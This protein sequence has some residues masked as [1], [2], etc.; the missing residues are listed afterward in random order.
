MESKI[1]DLYEYFNIPRNGAAAG[2]L[3]TYLRTPSL[4]IKAK[5]RPAVL[6]I[7]GGAYTMVSDREGEPVALSFLSEGYCAFLL[8]YTTHTAYPTPLIEACMA[9][10]YIRENA[11]K[12]GIDPN[13][14][15][16]IGFSAGGHLTG[17]L[18][19][20]SGEKEIEDALVDKC[21]LAKPNAVILSYPV[22]TME[23][24][25]THGDTRRIIS[26]DGALPYDKLSIEKRVTD[27]SVPA[28][29]WHTME[30][31][32]VPVENSLNL[33]SAYKKVGVPFALHI[34]ERGF[35]GLSLCNEEVF[36]SEEIYKSFGHVDRWFDLALD[37]LK[38]RGF[39]V[40]VK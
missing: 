16:A 28:F 3:T 1:I 38:M 21:C 24:K 10:V 20:M 12:F 6:V 2:Y 34:F 35:H 32:C 23:D 30:D 17:M 40:K 33:A 4:E 27:N 36:D 25:F 7:P 31:N 13:S 14:V 11:D 19:T 29:I 8:K 39:E 9:M 18:A 37:W 26:G 22:I 5:I 15:V